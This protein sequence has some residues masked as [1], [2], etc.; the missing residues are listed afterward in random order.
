MVD[1]IVAA[2]NFTKWVSLS[3][4]VVTLAIYLKKDHDFSK[5]VVIALAGSA[6]EDL[7]W[8]IHRFYWWAWRMLRSHGHDDLAAWLIDNG[9][10][11]LIASIP[12]FA[13]ASM[14]MAPV[15]SIYFGRWWP[16]ASASFIGCVFLVGLVLA[17]M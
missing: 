11:T 2:S 13:G 5:I 10:F 3:F 7:G 6:L 9:H 14:L 16:L 12:I 4:V 15:S 1:E 17:V 8:A